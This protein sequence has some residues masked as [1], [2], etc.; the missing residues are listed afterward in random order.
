MTRPTLLS[1]L[2]VLLPMATQA[3]VRVTVD[4]S[5][6]TLRPADGW[7]LWA[8]ERDGVPIF[9]DPGSSNGVILR[10][11]STWAGGRHGGSE[12]LDLSVHVDG[13]L[14]ADPI[15]GEELA[16]A[17]RVAL[18]LRQSYRGA[19]E[20]HTT[21]TFEA[22]AIHQTVSIRGL[23]PDLQITT[24]YV[25][26]W[27]RASH[28]GAARAYD[29]AGVEVPLTT[30]GSNRYGT[31]KVRRVVRDGDVRLATTWSASCDSTF[32]QQRSDGRSKLYCRFNDLL[33]AAN[34][35]WAGAIS[36][37]VVP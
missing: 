32:V 24:P 36:M 33:W 18:S 20:V 15:D 13:L 29:A 9:D 8:W 1:F 11:G 27:S 6:F 5:T 26:A 21:T 14:V 35:S 16:G 17:K 10:V 25:H 2:L 4:G 23:S 30:S 37:E 31:P 7:N 34:K 22:D 3:D 19:A 28:F 12:L